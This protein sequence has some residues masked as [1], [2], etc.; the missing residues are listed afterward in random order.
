MEGEA[1]VLWYAIVSMVLPGCGTAPKTTLNDDFSSV[2]LKYQTQAYDECLAVINKLMAKRPPPGSRAELWMC[3]GMCL[4]EKGNQSA[5]DQVY[6]KVKA[7]F[8]QTPYADW[9]QRRLERQD[10]DQKEHLAMAF[11]DERWQRHRKTVSPTGVRI[12]YH[13]RSED[14]RSGGAVIDFLS[15]DRPPEVK[16]LEDALALCESEFVSKGVR[17]KILLLEQTEDDAIWE[18]VLTANRRVPMAGVLRII[19]TPR[20]IHGIMG[21]PRTRSMSVEE[22]WEWVNRLKRATVVGSK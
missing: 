6:R 15:L 10:G 4:E 16:T 3:K 17:V 8:P 22:K 1:L 2:G 7:D 21:G 5:A 14:P 11:D 18:F 9:A 13:R 12:G 19:L 20:R